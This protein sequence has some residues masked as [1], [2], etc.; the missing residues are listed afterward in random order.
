MQFFYQT[1]PVFHSLIE[2]LYGEKVYEFLDI[3]YMLFGFDVRGMGINLQIN[4]VD[5]FPC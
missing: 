4:Y 3:H 2:F 1:C 5:I